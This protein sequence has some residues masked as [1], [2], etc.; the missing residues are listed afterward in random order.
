MYLDWMVVN[1]IFLARYIA[2]PTH[3]MKKYNSFIKG[4]ILFIIETI[5]LKKYKPNANIIV[6][7]Q[8]FVSFDI[9]FAMFKT[10]IYCPSTY[11]DV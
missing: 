7:I 10:F 9:F 6:S 2:V 8:N 11:D 5:F 3:N 4:N 1:Y